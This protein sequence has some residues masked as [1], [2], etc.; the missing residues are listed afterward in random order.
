MVKAYVGEPG[1]YGTLGRNRAVFYS[2][3]A[4]PRIVRLL[5]EAPPSVK[6]HIA[7]VSTEQAVRSVVHIQDQRD[8]LASLV[9][10]TSS[11]TEGHE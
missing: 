5:R 10:V 4:A 1:G 3:T 11:D 9:E 7:A 6:E 2:N 8:R